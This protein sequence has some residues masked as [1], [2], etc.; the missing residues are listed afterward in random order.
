M[1]AFVAAVVAAGREVAAA[2]ASSAA[3][4]P[5]ASACCPAASTSSCPDPAS[6]HLSLPA[7]WTP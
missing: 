6:E 7:T 3:F 5:T 4:C 1:T 2:E